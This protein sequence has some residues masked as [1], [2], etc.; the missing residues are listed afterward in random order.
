MDDQSRLK[1]ID[2]FMLN[3]EVPLDLDDLMMVLAEAYKVPI[4]LI[5]V[6]GE[7]EET[8]KAHYG[9]TLSKVTREHAFC[10]HVVEEREQVVVSNA[11]EDP[12]FM[13][14]PLVTG[15][16]HIC[17]YAG[18]PIEINDQVIGAVCLIDTVP[19][20]IDA[21]HL[22]VL[23]RIGALV[24]QH[25]SLS[26]EHEALKR[27]HG[28]IEKSP[29]VLAT[30]RYD[31]S[32]RLVY[33]S[34]NSER[35]LGVSPQD[36]L[37]GTVALSEVLSEEA[38]GDFTFAMQAH[39]EGVETHTCRL[40]IKTPTRTIWV[41]MI[42][43]ANFREDGM[44]Y[45]VQAFLF[46]TSDQKY[47][48]DKLNKTNQRMRLLLEASELGTW[49]WNLAA[50]VNQVNKRWCDIV[51]LE[52][53]YYD[54]GSRFFRQLIH[55]ADYVK[56]EKQLN[57]HLIGKSKVFNTTFRMKHT[58]GSWVWVES[59]GKTVETDAQGKPVR[60]A[61]IHRDITQ[62]MES[63]LH[64]RKKTQLLQFINKTRASYLQ[65][66]DLTMA[67]QSVLA[68]LIDISDS[69]FAFVGQMKG[70]GSSSRLFIHAISEIVWDN[71][72]FSQYAEYKKRNLYFSNFDNLF[73]TSIL[74][75]EVTISN[76]PNSHP[77]SKGVPHGHPR[78]SRFLGLPIKVK[79]KVVGMVGLAN[80]FDTYTD[81]DAE[82]LQPFL[83]ALAG[84]FYAV[85]L[86]EARAVAEEKL[87]H[88][89]MTDS[90]TGL[91]NRRAFL[92]ECISFSKQHCRGCVAIVDIDHFKK[93]NDTYGHDAGDQALIAVARKIAKHNQ[94]PNVVARLG[95]EEFAIVMIGD[96]KEEIHRQLEALRIAVEE[97]RVTYKTDTMN[98]SIS[99]GATFVKDTYEEDF[100]ALLSLADKA[101][102]RAKEQGRNQVV[103]DE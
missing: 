32:L 56:V 19:R 49:D 93:V 87:R 38:E 98:L 82:F 89:A 99:I 17:F 47:V 95:G 103:W 21:K 22:E 96:K 24:S 67:C 63:E 42:S 8:F 73:G 55:P 65:N 43:T 90:L 50:D 92:D 70:D 30:W 94:A 16:P 102:Y 88:L 23:E 10:S 11:Q 101:L 74:T 44:L 5:G 77:N 97:G 29:I 54:S 78:I 60:I 7:F 46:D 84:L 33:I 14:N 76:A 3:S 39:M 9:T 52:Y 58:D 20:E 25:I 85:E 91:Y 68:E 83:D 18:T 45:S 69:Q 62:R 15:E 31:T 79:D 59:Y 72:S 26:R 41:S 100:S 6:V 86:E 4:A 71:S 27:E 1:T 36:L 13:H 64:E 81:E 28:L 53:E 2:D 40:Q 66:N 80:K 51:G 57:M 75:G 48:E 34:K 35:V 12:R 37:T 61:G